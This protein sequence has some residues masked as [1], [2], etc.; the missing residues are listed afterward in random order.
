MV[1][2]GKTS[3]LA[4]GERCHLR[5]RAREERDCEGEP[6]CETG[7]VLAILEGKSARLGWGRAWPS[8][9]HWHAAPNGFAGVV[10]GAPT[11]RS[12][13]PGLVDPIALP[14]RQIGTATVHTGHAT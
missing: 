8:T 3:G 13:M 7:G 11:Q 5:Q 12:Q 14:S 10:G 1:P 2:V 9:T 4:K 6:R